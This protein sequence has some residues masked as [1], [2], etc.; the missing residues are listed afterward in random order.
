MAPC[1][2]ALTRCQLPEPCATVR[3]VQSSPFLTST[4]R[5]IRDE[6]AS[7]VGRLVFAW[8]NRS[9]PIRTNWPNEKSRV[10]SLQDRSFVAILGGF[11]SAIVDNER[12]GQFESTI[13]IRSRRR[14]RDRDRRR[15]TVRIDF[16]RIGE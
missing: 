7:R 2:A 13:L 8:E 16:E 4:R 14:K 6:R 12:R 15:S 3:T 10:S 9:C 5:R 11:G 1:A